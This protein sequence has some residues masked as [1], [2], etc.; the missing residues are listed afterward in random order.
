MVRYH[1]AARSALGLTPP[2]ATIGATAPG[3][4]GIPDAAAGALPL[5]PF[6]RW[7]TAEWAAELSGGWVEMLD[8]GK[9]IFDEVIERIDALRLSKLGCADQVEI[10][11]GAF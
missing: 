5:G 10:E 4:K 8:L 2:L 11:L 1:R 9:P 6:G 3:L 7:L